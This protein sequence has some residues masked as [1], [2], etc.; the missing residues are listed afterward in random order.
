M[1][2]FISFGGLPS[3]VVRFFRIF[4]RPFIARGDDDEFHYGAMLRR[5]FLSLV[6]HGELMAGL[7]MMD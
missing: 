3:G 7:A 4:G 6:C 1:C 2:C 5:G